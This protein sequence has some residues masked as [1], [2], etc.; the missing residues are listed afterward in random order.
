MTVDAADGLELLF[1]LFIDIVVAL[2]NL[3]AS[4]RAHSLK[5]PWYEYGCAVIIIIIRLIF[6]VYILMF[7]RINR[8]SQT[9]S[10]IN[11]DY[12]ILPLFWYLSFKYISNNIGI[13]ILFTFDSINS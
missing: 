9:D 1:L 5:R 2:K 12:K 8:T 4:H 10:R 11:Y 6:V 7:V 13:L 3:I